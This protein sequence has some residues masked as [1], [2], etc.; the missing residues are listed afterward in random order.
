MLYFPHMTVELAE[1]VHLSGLLWAN[2]F[3]RES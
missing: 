3:A 1:S 2:C